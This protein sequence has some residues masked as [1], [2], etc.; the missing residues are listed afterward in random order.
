M[1]VL[2]VMLDRSGYGAVTVLRNV[3]IEVDEGELVAVLG[4]N[5]AGKTTLLRTIS[6]LMV[7]ASGRIV[8]DGRPVTRMAAFR[9]A[10]IGITHVPEGRHVFSGLSVEENLDMG[11]HAAK[12]RSGPRDASYDRVYELF[13]ALQQ[14][15][16]DQATSLSGGQQQMLA[17]GRALMAHPRLLM[18]DEAS[19]GLSPTLT[20]EVLSALHQIRAQGTAVLM[21]E[22]N[23]RAALR[24]A[25]RAYVLERGR[26]VL[27]GAGTELLSDGRLTSLYLGGHSEPIGGQE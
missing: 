13:P 18:V 10:Q 20:Q 4:S 15:A 2:E 7:R 25:D 17:I 23:A 19:L 24:V 14:R 5:G 11:S 3:G 16:T 22:Q 26:V 1:P 9:R 12:S 8:F 21:V 6:G 27:T